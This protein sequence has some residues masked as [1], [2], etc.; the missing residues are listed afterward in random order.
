MVRSIIMMSYKIEVHPRDRRISIAS[1]YP[2]N[3]YNEVYFDIRQIPELINALRE[4]E[5]VLKKG[6]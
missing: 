2:D 3:T 5:D 1:V 6:E 4:A